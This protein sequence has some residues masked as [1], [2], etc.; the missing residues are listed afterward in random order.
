MIDIRKWGVATCL[1]LLI[2]AGP[3]RQGRLL[4]YSNGQTLAGDYKPPGTRFR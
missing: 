4:T 3:A 1:S 2:L